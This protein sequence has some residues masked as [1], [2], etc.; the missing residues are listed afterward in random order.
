MSNG[1]TPDDRRQ[2]TRHAVA[3]L[4]ARR[5]LLFDE[6][7]DWQVRAVIRRE[8]DE[9]LQAGREAREKPVGFRLYEQN[10]VRPLPE[11]QRIVWNEG[12]ALGWIIAVDGAVIT[13]LTRARA[14]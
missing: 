11:G 10:K 6:L 13:S 2:V 3:Q 8:V 12:G 14:A 7:D 5:P 4:R 9:A 1:S